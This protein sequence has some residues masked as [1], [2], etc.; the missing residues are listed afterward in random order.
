[1]HIGA[2]PGFV[3]YLEYKRGVGK[4]TGEED[5]IEEDLKLLFKRVMDSQI[6]F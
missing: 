5:G 2:T 1:M 6:R 3:S 4:K